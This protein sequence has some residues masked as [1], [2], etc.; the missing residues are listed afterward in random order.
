M[1]EMIDIIIYFL[2][3]SLS[4]FLGI[5]YEKDRKEFKRINKIGHNIS[6]QDDK[7]KS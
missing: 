3:V 2:I 6:P 4:F 7:P 5:T 1:K